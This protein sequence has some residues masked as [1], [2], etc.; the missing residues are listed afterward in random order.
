MDETSYGKDPE[1]D[2]TLREEQERREQDEEF[3]RRVRRE[4]RR[5]NRGEAD[6]DMD[7]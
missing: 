6:R 1:I 3:A 2:P 5:I 4:V 7:E